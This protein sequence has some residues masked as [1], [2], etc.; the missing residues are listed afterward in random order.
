MKISIFGLG[1][2][3]AVSAGCLAKDGHEVIGVD[4]ND[5]KVDLINGGQS[6]IVERD[7]G[8]MIA[9]A[10][11][12]K[13]LRATTNARDAVFES[14]ISLV[15]V[16][17]PSE[18]NGSLDLRYVRSVCGE[19]GTALAE[20]GGRH[21]VVMR[22]T[23]LPGTMRELVIPTLEEHSGKRA[24]TEFSVCNNPEFL[25]EGTAVYDYYNPPKTVI[26]ELAPGDGDEIAEIYADLSAPL[27]RTDVNTAEMVKYVDN[28][29]HALKVGFANE[30]GSATPWLARLRNLP[31]NR[32]ALPCMIVSILALLQLESR[33]LDVYTAIGFGLM[34]YFW[35]AHGWPRVPF[36]IAFV[37]GS[38]IETNLV[39]TSQLIEFGR[40]VPQERIASVIL[41]AMILGSILWLRTKRT[42][43][44][45][46]TVAMCTDVTLG[47]LTTLVAGALS[48]IAFF[49]GSGYSWYA[50]GLILLC[51]GLGLMISGLSLR[52]LHRSS[53]TL[54][55][56][57]LLWVAH[58]APPPEQRMPIALM[59]FLTMAIWLA[60]VS[61]AIGLVATI[62]FFIRSNP[63]LTGRLRAVAFGILVG[64]GT[65]YFINNFA[66][67]ILPD[68]R[69]ASFLGI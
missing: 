29:W 65:F 23:M 69:L 49:G 18:E 66:N 5:T 19:I 32:L 61:I 56:Q 1:Y 34:G 38:L 6:P 9:E 48:L 42:D 50:K 21:A 54:F 37:L 12:A 3:G 52:E 53:A 44:D 47:V 24:G 14:D 28:V 11:D 59:L 22:S 27:I 39:L 57:P 25:R 8:D 41:I 68:S 45:R 26:G 4:P 58:L 2:V 31:I 55:R 20:K 67:L 63:T 33:L 40:I 43:P 35:R 60:G 30:V 7:I 10:V 46:S 51:V 16:G 13:R 62:W 15:C 64:S 36:V 17:T